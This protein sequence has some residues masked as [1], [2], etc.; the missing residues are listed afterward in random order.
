MHEHACSIYLVAYR[1]EFKKTEWNGAKDFE[2]AFV[3]IC[4]VFCF[5]RFEVPDRVGRVTELW[6]KQVMVSHYW[7]AWFG[8]DWR[9]R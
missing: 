6:A 3:M 8:A 2:L 1:D 9:I 7:G 5:G 4:K